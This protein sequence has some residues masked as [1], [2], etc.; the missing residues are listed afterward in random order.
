MLIVV[1]IIHLLPLSG[2]LGAE[3]L[4]AL[5]GVAFEEPNLL[6]L[7]RHRA[8]LFG[9]LGVL[10]LL[11]AARPA[12]QPLALASG[13][14]SVASFVWLAWSAGGVNAALGRVVMVDLV[15]IACLVVAALSW[16]LTP[17]RA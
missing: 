5:Y 13:F 14:V 17:G 3:R 16:A 1:G 10:L 6:V 9:L 2:V 8:V 12:L 15:A 7:M 11:A 4:T